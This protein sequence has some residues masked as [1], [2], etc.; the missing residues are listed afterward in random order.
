MTRGYSDDVVELTPRMRAVLLSASLGRTAGETALELRVSE[1]TVW[2]V[3]AAACAR[4]GAANVTA[5][6]TIAIRAGEL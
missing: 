5:A 3:R 4:L 2:S 1:A 6:V